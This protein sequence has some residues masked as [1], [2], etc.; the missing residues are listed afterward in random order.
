MTDKVFKILDESDV[1]F[2]N[3]KKNFKKIGLP[4]KYRDQL[5]EV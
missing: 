1:S 2:L 3:A 4:M 5:T